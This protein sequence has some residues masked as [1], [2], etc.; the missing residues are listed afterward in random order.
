MARLVE[1]AATCSRKDV[2]WARTVPKIQLVVNS[3]L[4]VLVDP[5]LMAVFHPNATPVKRAEMERRGFEWMI[6]FPMYSVS[7]MGR[8]PIAIRAKPTT[9]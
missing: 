5:T 4:W 6:K 8:S 3:V 1:R 2:V 7:N 9:G